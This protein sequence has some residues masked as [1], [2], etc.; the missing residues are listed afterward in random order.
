MLRKWNRFLAFLL[1]IALVT[2]TFGSDFASAKVYAVEGIEDAEPAEEAEP[3][4]V[5]ESEEDEEPAEAVEPAEDAE[6]Q[7]V[8]GAEEAAA[9]A[10]P[11][12]LLLRRLPAH[13]LRTLQVQQLMRLLM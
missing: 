11:S 13:S 8:A 9:A 2:T 7:E 3:E 1:T 5:V 10:S 12:F 6:P 4:E